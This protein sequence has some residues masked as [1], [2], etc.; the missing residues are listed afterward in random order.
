MAGLIDLPPELILHLISFLTCEKILDKDNCILGRPRGYYKPRVIELVPDLPSINSLSQTATV[1]HRTLDEALYKLGASS[2]TLGQL[3]LLST[4]KRQLENAVERLVAAGVSLQAQFLFEY[5]LECTV[6]HI[7]AGLGLR[8]MVVKLLG[9]CGE[10]MVH[11]RAEGRPGRTALDYAARNNHLEIVKLLAPIPVPDSSTRN[12]VPLPDTIEAQYLSIALLAAVQVGNTEVS[13]YLVSEGADVNFL[14][15]WAGGTPL[16]YAAKTKNLGLVQFLV[17]AG[18]DPN[19]QANNTIPLFNATLTRNLEI[20]QALVA[21]GADIHVQSRDQ[22]NV[23]VC[24]A[25]VELLRFFLERGVDPN[26]ED[27]DGN[28]PLHH[29]CARAK[30]EFAAAAVELLLRFGAAVTVE[31]PGQYGFT[32][33]DIAVA[34]YDTETL[35]LLEPL[36]QDTDLKGKIAA[37]WKELEERNPK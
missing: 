9:M 26:L 24:C 28:T 34:R 30:T 11:R 5:S 16:S 13:E 17:S 15:L 12:G 10:E 35:E 7:A 4:V 14:A 6:L 25:T 22:H 31:K 2:E 20:V 36:V 33:V 8:D 32:P 1:F 29:V 21:A 19:L 23:L 27:R 3:A 37:R 18:A